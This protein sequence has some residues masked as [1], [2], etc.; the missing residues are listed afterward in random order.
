MI[1]LDYSDKRCIYEQ[2]VDKF[3][4]LVYKGVLKADD[5]M[6]SVRSLAM[7]LSINPNT[8]QKAYAQL[9]RDGFIYTV[10][11]RGNYVADICGLLPKRQQDFYEEMDLMLDK[12]PD[13]GIREDELISHIRNYINEG[14]NSND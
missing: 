2:V 13:L 3:K 1:V 4:E 12:L 5:Q 7:D 14:G 6:P 10:K 11:G 9:E 8:I